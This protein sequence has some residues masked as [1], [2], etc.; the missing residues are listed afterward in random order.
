[1]EKK[2][3]CGGDGHVLALPYPSQGHIN[4]MLQFC[5]RLVSKGLNKV[6]LATPIFI[7]NTFK[8]QA[9]LLGSVQLDTIS[10]GFDDGGFMQADSIHHYLTKLQSSGST[11]LAQLIQ[12]HADLGQPFDCI[13]Y[14]AFLPWAL[15]VA[16]QFG[17][18]GAAFFTQACAV[19]YIYY[20]AYHG[21]LPLLNSTTTTTDHHPVTNIPGL[22]SLKLRDMPSFIYV[23]GSYPA[24][25]Q[26]V[27]NQFSNVH[28]A[29]W[30]LVNT[31]YKLEEEVRCICLF[32]FYSNSQLL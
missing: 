18:V 7:S 11:T 25:F 1:M 31:F 17:I 27:L 10:D 22:P 19:N 32:I 24:Y 30:V 13:V 2:K 20:H 9:L 26:M 16:K 8:P 5:R 29:D 21:Q 6:T 4:P 28:K 15:D 23:A 12:K 3:R 14:D